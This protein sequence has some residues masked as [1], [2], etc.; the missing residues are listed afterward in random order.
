MKHSIRGLVLVCVA[1]LVVS[2]TSGGGGGTP[3]STAVIR[4]TVLDSVDVPVSGATVHCPGLSSVQTG[5]DGRFEMQ[6]SIGP[7]K[8]TISKDGVTVTEQCLTVAELVTYELGTITPT[9]PTNCDTVCTNSADSADPDCDGLSADIET[10]GWDVVITQGDGTTETRHVASDP[11]L[12]DTDNDGLSDSEEFASRTDPT[13]SDTDGDMLSDYAELKV[14]K[15]NPLRAD[16]DGDSTGPIGDKPSDPNLW[17]GYEVLVSHTS[18]VL[19]DTDGDGKTDWEEIHSG[20]T[21]PL[22]ADLPVLA[23]EVYGDPHIALNVSIVSGCSKTSTDLVREAQE[24]VNTDK[25][26]T[27]MSIKNTVNLHTEAEAGT[28]TWPPSFNAKITTDTEFKQGYIHETS[29]NFTQTSVQD[30]QTLASCWEENNANFANGRISVAMK[31]RNLSSL[32]F[33]VKDLTVIAYQV[34]TG[35][36]FRLVGTLTPTPDLSAGGVVMGPFGDITMTFEKTDI[37]AVT[38]K[39]LVDNPAALMFEVG[40]YSLFQ[41]DEWGVNETVNFAKLGESVVQQTGLFTI[42]YGDGTVER[43]MI[44]TNVNR[45]PD[46]TAAGITLR[47]ALTNVLKISYETETQKD[48]AGSVIGEKVLKKVKT[49]ATF[50]NDPNQQGRGFWIVGG[51]SDAF[52]SGIATNFDDIVLKNGERISIVFLLDTDLDGLFDNEERLLGTD[53]NSQ[54]TDGDGVSD[55]EE[56]KV[57]WDVTVNGTITYHVYSDPRFIDV[58]GD[59][60]NDAQERAFGTDPYKEDTDGDG[61]FDTND[62]YPLS[63]PCLAGKLLGLAA[64]WNGS[65]TGSSP[66]LTAL[67]IWSGPTHSATADPNGYASNGA[68]SGTVPSITWKPLYDSTPGLNPVFNFNT[69]GTTQHDQQIAV[70]DTAALD[71]G[72]SL[73]PQAVTLSAWVYWNGNATNAAWATILSKGAPATASYALLVGTDGTVKFSIYRNVHYKCFGWFFGWIDGLCADSDGNLLDELL[74]PRLPLNEWAHVTA[75]WS[76]ASE[77]MKVYVEYNGARPSS[78]RATWRYYNGPDYLYTNYLVTN[79]DP[80]RIGLDAV[81]ASSVWPFRG[82]LDDVQVYGREMTLNEVILFNGIGICAP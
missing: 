62:P 53:I 13:R 43:H 26:S 81:P 78:E 51:N 5:T 10:A 42:D 47:E 40:A 1:L 38:M 67:D 25:V 44:A 24:R 29:A 22:I 73:S 72:R 74:G 36:S 37:D 3:E 56:A 79:T 82:M 33:K 50:Q 2:C 19:V 14:Y 77:K 20:G 6:T 15:S 41:L 63:P 55:Y 27:E 30:A 61:P 80:L 76:A 75:T 31:L 52:A 48:S 32:S 12:K 71:S 9:S 69:T 49:T 59:Y 39:A 60:L 58:D 54:D 11:A 46:G 23:L 66:T 8:L 64:W 7:K 16:T 28:G 65:T 70:A 34:T 4:G 18:P 68:L 21:S 57:G 35:S 17:D 45:N